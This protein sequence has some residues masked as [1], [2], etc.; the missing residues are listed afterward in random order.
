MAQCQKFRLLFNIK[1]YK[2]LKCFFLLIT[3]INCLSFCL[4]QCDNGTFYVAATNKC[5]KCPVGTFNTDGNAS[6]C[7]ACPYGYIGETEGLSVC[8]K[9]DKPENCPV[10][11][12]N[13]LS[14]TQVNIRNGNKM[15]QYNNSEAM[16]LRVY[17]LVFR[18]GLVH[19]MD[20]WL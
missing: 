2:I 12:F 18:F 15:K 17:P 7:R 5:E 8:V 3:F 13:T 20:G 10:G 16:L 11:T 6:K 14:S 1:Y 19:F 4:G 9:C